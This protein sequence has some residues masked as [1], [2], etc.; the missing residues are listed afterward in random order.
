MSF[1]VT[2]VITTYR[3]RPEIVRRALNS[4]VNQTYNSLEIIVVNDAPEEHKL[5]EELRE[6][7]SELN[8]KKNIKYV[9]MKKIVGRAQQEIRPLNLLVVTASLFLMMM[10]NGCRKK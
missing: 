2:T 8:T 6:L 10:M 7:C 4:I 9:V 1:L 5:V 3:R